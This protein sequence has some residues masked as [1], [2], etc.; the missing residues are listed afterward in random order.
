[1]GLVFL[2]VWCNQQVGSVTGMVC[3]VISNRST[4]EWLFWCHTVAYLYTWAETRYIWKHGKSGCDSI[5]QRKRKGFSACRQPEAE[6][7]PLIIQIG[8][9][10][11]LVSKATRLLTKLGR[12]KKWLLTNNIKLTLEKKVVFHCKEWW[13]AS[14]FIL[15]QGLFEIIAQSADWTAILFLGMYVDVA[16]KLVLWD[17]LHFGVLSHT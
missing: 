3:L 4:Y 7:N 8:P 13:A 9:M 12:S 10:S 15:F 2:V 5:T 6:L 1:M 17:F 14:L 16:R 11:L